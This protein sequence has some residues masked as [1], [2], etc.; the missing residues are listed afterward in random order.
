L[1]LRSVFT[2]QQ[3]RWNTVRGNRK[4]INQYVRTIAS[5]R[6]AYCDSDDCRM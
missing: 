1:L 2:V 6:S 5:T 3:I 4:R